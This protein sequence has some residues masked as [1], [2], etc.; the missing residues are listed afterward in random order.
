MPQ[1][2]N[3]S[4]HGARTRV[5]RSLEGAHRSLTRK[6]HGLQ[7]GHQARAGMRAQRL[8][9]GREAGH[10]LGRLLPAPHPLENLP[11]AYG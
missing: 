2:H 10:S 7:L 8:L 5:L 1:V 3:A 4:E 9:Q 6:A 11:T